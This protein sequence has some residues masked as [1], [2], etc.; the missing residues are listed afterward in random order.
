M[1]YASTL[2]I[3]VCAVTNAF[4]CNECN[5]KI[6]FKTIFF[7]DSLLHTNAKKFQIIPISRF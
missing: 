1:Y 6:N 2:Y 7:V 4:P 3:C 5:L